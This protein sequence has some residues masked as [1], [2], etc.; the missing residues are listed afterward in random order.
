MK[1][2][3]RI[4]FKFFVI[5]TSPKFQRDFFFVKHVKSFLCKSGKDSS[6][7]EAR[8]K[9]EDYCVPCACAFLLLLCTVGLLILWGLH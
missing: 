3:R 2:P 4:K 5:P 8:L 1:I 7:K 9:V 6:R